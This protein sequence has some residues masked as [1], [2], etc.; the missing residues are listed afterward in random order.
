[1]RCIEDVWEIMQ[2]AIDQSQ[3]R[4]G[5]AATLLEHLLKTAQKNKITKIQLEVRAKNQVAI[6]LYHQYGFKKAG[7]RKNYY[8]DGEDA[9][10][11]DLIM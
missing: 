10:L 8:G 9:L 1:M 6:A 11:F 7:Q 3:Y 5:F 2:I 4:K